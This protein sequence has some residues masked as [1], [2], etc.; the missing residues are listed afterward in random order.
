[1]KIRSIYVAGLLLLLVTL[2]LGSFIILHHYA[3]GVLLFNLRNFLVA[4]PYNPGLLLLLLTLVLTPF[5]LLMLYLLIMPGRKRPAHDPLVLHVSDGKKIQAENQQIIA[6]LQRLL[7]QPEGVK[8]APVHL[9]E[10][11]P[12]QPLKVSYPSLDAEALQLQ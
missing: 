1:M 12:K 7:Q 11:R 2:T 10:E 4:K 5:P 3:F 8:S 6:Q 9:S